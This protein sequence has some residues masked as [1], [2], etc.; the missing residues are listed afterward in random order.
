MLYSQIKIA[1]RSLLSN[2]L[3][4]AI[5]VIGLSIGMAVAFLIFLW[6]QNELRFDNFHPEADKIY[7]AI[8]HIDL[9]DEYWHWGTV[10][11]QLTEKAQREI[12][13]VQAL[14]K[15]RIQRRALL[16]LEDGSLYEDHTIAFVDTH[17]F[18]M[19]S[20]KEVDGT[21]PSFFS[22]VSSI[23]LTEDLS[24]HLFGEE[25]A[26]GQI[27]QIDSVPYQVSLILEKNPT[28]TI[29]QFQAFIPL[30][31]RWVKE[32]QLQQD[33]EWGNYD[34][35]AFIKGSHRT[36]IEEKLTSFIPIDEEYPEDQN[37]IS[38]LPIQDVRFDQNGRIRYVRTSE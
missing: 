11:L 27:I 10:P 21:V 29:L 22:S 5:N 26:L 3:F 13:E 25:G 20:Y 15:A 31:A 36:A 14:T 24:K 28:N 35:L 7:R 34:Y 33:L 1:F 37:Y 4:T 30:E 17:W 12:P 18:E 38:L 23:A 32:K 9:G 2:K 16:K 19:F 8:S 6:V